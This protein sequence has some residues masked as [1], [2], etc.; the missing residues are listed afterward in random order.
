MKELEKEYF[1]KHKPTLKDKMEDWYYG[2]LDRIVDD[3]MM[4]LILSLCTVLGI[5]VLIKLLF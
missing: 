2:L 5:Y 1:D 3:N 4:I